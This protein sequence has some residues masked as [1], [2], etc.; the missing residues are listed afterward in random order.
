LDVCVVTFRNDERRIRDALRPGDKL[1]VHDNTCPN[2]GFAA[3]ANAAAK[4]GNAAFILFI[5]PDGDPGPGLLDALEEALAQP[6]VVAVEADVG[7]RANN[8]GDRDPEWL[9]GACMIV[10]RMD[11]EAVGGFDERFFMY[12]ED[13][14]LSYKLQKRGR[15]AHC[16]TAHFSHDAGGRGYLALHRVYRNWC[17]VRRRYRGSAR[18]WRL[19]RDARVALRERRFGQAAAMLTGIADYLVRGYRWA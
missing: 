13:V 18:P 7:V 17:V 4:M 14:D 2:L 11:F 3:G 16:A 15:L 5:N 19:A 12:C 9:D 1:L 8:W 6:D 10:R